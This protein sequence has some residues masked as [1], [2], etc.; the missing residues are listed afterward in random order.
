[1]ESLKKLDLNVN[2]GGNYYAEITLNILYFRQF[3]IFTDSAL[4]AIINNK[5]LG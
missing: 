5:L 3:M 1:M 2:R 4:L